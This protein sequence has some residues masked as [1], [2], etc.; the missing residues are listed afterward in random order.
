MV[1]NDMCYCCFAHNIPQPLTRQAHS[2]MNAALGAERLEGVIGEWS[3][4]G[5]QRI[6][7]LHELLDSLL[8]CHKEQPNSAF[9]IV[10][11]VKKVFKFDF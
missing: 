9:M 2:Q 8:S 3:H 6:S 5:V 7:A 1:S 11:P 4:V 10:K